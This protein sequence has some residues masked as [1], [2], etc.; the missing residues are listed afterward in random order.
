MT[1]ERDCGPEV[2]AGAALLGDGRAE[3]GALAIA[4]TRHDG[5]ARWQPGRLRRIGRELAHYRPRGHERREP[6]LFEADEVEQRGCIRERAHVEDA[7]RVRA[8]PARHPSAREP[9][10][11]EGVHVRHHHGPLQDL[12]LMVREPGELVQRW[13]RAGRLT[14]ETVDLRR[15]EPPDLVDGAGVQPEDGRAQRLVVLVEAG[16]R[17]ALVRDAEGDDILGRAPATSACRSAS[18]VPCHQ[19][20]GSCSCHPGSGDALLRGDLAVATASPCE[21][22]ARALQAVVEASMATTRGPRRERTR[23]D[24]PC[25]GR[26]IPPAG[27]RPV[28]QG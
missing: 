5:K 1:A 13:R 10:Y 25:R 17:L 27:G 9:S 18:Q 11:E 4:G 14:G 6:L 12:G 28:T 8:G 24:A 3:G 21:S 15:P 19:A 20:S 23:P 2:E 22:K 7:Q 26:V 16:E